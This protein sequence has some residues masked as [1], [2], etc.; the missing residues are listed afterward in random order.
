MQGCRC[1]EAVAVGSLARGDSAE[2]GPRARRFAALHSGAVDPPRA[3]R[4]A[5]LYCTSLVS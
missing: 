3:V 5:L 1:E 4:I 2:V